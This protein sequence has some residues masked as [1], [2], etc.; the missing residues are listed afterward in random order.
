MVFIEKYSYQLGRI[1]GDIIV[2]SLLPT[3]GLIV[4]TSVKKF[5]NFADKH[6]IAKYGK[7]YI[8]QN[9]FDCLP[10]IE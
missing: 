2:V 3:S 6:S 10:Y 1:I 7:D 5:C 8:T 9:L 4:Y